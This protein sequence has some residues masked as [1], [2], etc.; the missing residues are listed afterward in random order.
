MALTDKKIQGST[1]IREFPDKYNGLITE[2]IQ[3]LD[4]KNTQIASL[5]AEINR[6]NSELASG[7][8]TLRAKYESR[9]DQEWETRIQN[10]FDAKMNDFEK[11]FVKK[12]DI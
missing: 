1:P 8:A 3:E 6:L 9:F 5:Q 4:E 2:L 12:T 11:K 10:M 7:L